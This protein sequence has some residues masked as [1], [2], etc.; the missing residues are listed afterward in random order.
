MSKSGELNHRNE[1]MR[2]KIVTQHVH[3]G[4]ALSNAL[5]D[6]HTRIS[7]VAREIGVGPQQISRWKN[8]SDIKLSRAVEIA[9]VFG[10]SL[11]AFL[12]AYHE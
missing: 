5:E 8:S 4:K 1:K 9:S 7:D 10:M 12:D 11:S 3:F 6:S 2:N